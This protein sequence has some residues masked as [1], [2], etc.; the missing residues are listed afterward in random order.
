MT[1]FLF[2]STL[3]W[4]F[5]G[6]CVTILNYKK[7]F[8]PNKS[9][10]CFVSSKY[11]EII[12]SFQNHHMV[13]LIFLFEKHCLGQRG[14]GCTR[15]IPLPSLSVS[16][17]KFRRLF[18]KIDHICP[19]IFMKLIKSCSL[20]R[21]NK[22]PAKQ[23]HNLCSSAQQRGLHFTISLERLDQRFSPLSLMTM[24][25]ITINKRGWISCI[26]FRRLP[27]FKFYISSI[28][29]SLFFFLPLLNISFSGLKVLDIM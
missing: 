11:F 9:K 17:I 12:L 5:C 13:S 26:I 8:L 7:I 18:L 14:K 4:I 27:W 28:V 10:C 3:V 20:F 16:M 2:K 25:M 6:R 19:L 29:F 22:L 1:S 21:W 24:I 15:K 23:K